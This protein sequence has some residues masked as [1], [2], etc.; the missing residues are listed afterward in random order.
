MAQNIM[1]ILARDDLNPVLASLIG[2]CCGSES[3]F[4]I[5]RQHLS[6][7]GFAHYGDLCPDTDSQ[8]DG[9]GPGTVAELL[10]QALALSGDRPPGPVVDLGCAVG[11]SSFELAG[12]TNDLVLGID[13]NF[14]MLRMASAIGRRQKVAFG[15]RRGG[16]VY[17]W[18]EYPAH[19]PGA[20][21]VDFWLC[22]VLNLPFADASFSM[23]ASLNLLDVV[24]SPY[25]H[26]KEMSR[27]LAP[28]GPALVA[29]PFDWSPRV[30]AV[31]SWIGGH[32]QRGVN[33][34]NSV[35]GL[36]DLLAGGDNIQALADLAMAAEPRD[37]PWILRLHDRSCVHY[38]VYLAILRKKTALPTAGPPT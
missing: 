4:D 12:D 34:G 37:I 33:H 9:A 25:D 5:H 30:T 29:T 14:S 22:D 17:D 11:R 1:P 16:L 6:T 13:L 28:S 27:V 2:D 26:L 18:L 10:G 7:Y 38:L 31:E 19:F 36:A 32:S 23:A 35:A 20:E 21:K 3:A 15:L 24:S 8:H